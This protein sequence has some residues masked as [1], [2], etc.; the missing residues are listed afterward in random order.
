MAVVAAQDVPTTRQIEVTLTEGTS[1][2][3][4]VSPAGRSIAIDLLGGIWVLPF[5]GGEAKRITP[6]LLEARLPTWSPDGQSI[7][8]QGYDDGT[9]HIYVISRD[10][11]DVRRLT[12]G[13]FDDREPAWSH[14]GTRIAF[15]SDRYGGI[16]TIWALT[17]ATGDVRR[18]TSRDGV[19][20][21]WTPNDQAIAFVS[22]DSGHTGPDATDRAIPGL[23]SLNARVASACC[24]AE[25]DRH[26]HHA[27]SRRL[28]PTG[29]SFARSRRKAASLSWSR[30]I[31]RRRRRVPAPPHWISSE[32]ICTA[33]GHRAP[34]DRRR[35]GVVPFS[36]GHLQEVL[37]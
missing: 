4:A 16:C 8:F 37:T 30:P 35:D 31:S 9:W 28:S 14:D 25:R 2:S 23:W 24:S 19:M 5:R 20:P 10:G 34:L 18:L 15:S 26:R 21:T 32:F 22:R 3:A 17:V 36:D 12:S 13:E 27:G 6:E 7:A 33:D 11:G 1:M 29:R